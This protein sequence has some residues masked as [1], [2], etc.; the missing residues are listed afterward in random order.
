MRADAMRRGGAAVAALLAGSFACAEPQGEA[1]FVAFEDA[2][3]AYE[4]VGTGDPIVVVHGGPGLDRSYLR[5]GIDVLASGHQLVFFDQRGTGESESELTDE[6]INLDRFVEDIDV[7]REHLGHDRIT[8]L[9]HSFG[10]LIGTRYAIRF[11]D[12]LNAL[13]LANPV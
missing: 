2:T 4:V 13:V 1:G 11:P 10:S 6:A 3:L 8:V 5:P 9:A 7:L 12:R